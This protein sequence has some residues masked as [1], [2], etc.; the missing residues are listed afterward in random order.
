MGVHH[1]LR[2]QRNMQLY[3]ATFRNRAREHDNDPASLFGVRT[4]SYAEMVLRSRHPQ[5]AKKCVGHV[6]VI[7]LARMDNFRNAPGL[8]H[9]CVVERRYLHEIGT[10]GRYQVDLLG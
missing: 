1:T 10:R 3:V 6:R 4:A 7:V 9:E 8:G 5:I 2:W